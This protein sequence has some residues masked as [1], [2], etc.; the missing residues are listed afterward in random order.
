MSVC[1]SAA[2]CVHVNKVEVKQ[3]D[4]QDSIGESPVLTEFIRSD[5]LK[6]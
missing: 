1:V 6:L 3:G 4:V 2:V 5:S